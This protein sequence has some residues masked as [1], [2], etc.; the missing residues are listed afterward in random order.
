MGYYFMSEWKYSP[1]WSEEDLTDGRYIGFVYMFYFPDTGETYYGVKQMYKRVK[2]VKKLK[3]D[4]V[5]NGWRE[6][7]SSSKKVNSMIESGMEYERTILWGFPSMSEA[8]Y[9]ETLLIT[10]FSL[11]SNNLN[12]AI[13]SKCRIPNGDKR[14]RMKGIMK[15][16]FGWLEGYG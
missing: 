1:D 10:H 4:S 3:I 13:M 12:M 7:T 2:D 15:T 14:I 8:T 5:E 11:E 16:I 9:A 6:Y